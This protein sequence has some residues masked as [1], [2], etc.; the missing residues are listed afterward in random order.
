MRLLKCC[1]KYGSKFGK[2]SGGHRT[3]KGQC[4]SQFPRRAVP[5]NVQTT[6]QLC[7][8]PMLVRF[9]SKCFK[10]GFSSMWTE[11]FQMYKLEFEK[12]EEPEIKMPTLVGSQR[13]QGNSRKTST[14]PSLTVLKS[15]TLYITTNCGKFLK[16][17]NTRPPYLPPEKSVCRS[18]SNS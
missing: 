1:T 9:C 6:G 11:N 16:G 13:K 8:F 4:S 12:A 5:K 17:W 7:S 14:S 10:L 2:T 18:G 3:E 15:L